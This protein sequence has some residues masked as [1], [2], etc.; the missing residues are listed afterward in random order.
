MIS[1]N[2]WKRLIGKNLIK[3]IERAKSNTLVIRPYIKNLIKRIE[4]I[5]E[6]TRSI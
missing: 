4:S 6:P 5:L 3:R 2:G 1:K